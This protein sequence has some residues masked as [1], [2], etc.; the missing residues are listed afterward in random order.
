MTTQDE[1]QFKLE[2]QGAPEPLAVP[3]IYEG[4]RQWSQDKF[5]V[6]PGSTVTSVNQAPY[7]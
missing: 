6:R 3:N 5:T 4:V 7:F 2:M 1:A